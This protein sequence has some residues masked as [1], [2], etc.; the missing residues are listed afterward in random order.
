MRIRLNSVWQT[1]LRCSRKKIKRLKSYK[2]KTM[3][4][5]TNCSKESFSHHVIPFLIPSTLHLDLLNNTYTS[6]IC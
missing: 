6:R 4:S 5:S 1:E 3:L 2:A